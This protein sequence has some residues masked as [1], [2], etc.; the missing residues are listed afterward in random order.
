MRHRP[1][2]H[3]R[4]RRAKQDRL[5]ELRARVAEAAAAHEAGAARLADYESLVRSAE[6]RQGDLAAALG[7]ALGDLEVE[8]KIAA[9][10]LITQG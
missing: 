4:L 7:E 1:Q 3:P 6:R 10:P 9:N 2:P 8:E 5:A